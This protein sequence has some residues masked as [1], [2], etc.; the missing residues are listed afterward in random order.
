M[1]SE[2][3]WFTLSHYL[4]DECLQF[5][6]LVCLC[7]LYYITAWR[8]VGFRGSHS[9]SQAT[10]FKDMKIV[11]LPALQDNYMYLV[12]DEATKQAAIVDPV[13]PDTVLEAVK[14]QGVQ[15][16]SILTTH[17]HWDHAGGNEELAK[18][19]PGLEVYGGDERIGALT[20]RV[21]HGDEFQVGQLTVQCLFTP[22]HTSG[23]VCYFVQS[24][25]ETPAVF[26]GDTLF[27]AGCGRFFEG[28]PEQMYKALIEILGS[29]P[30][31]TRVFCGHEYTL[32][33]LKFA[34]HVEPDNEAVKNKMTWAKMKRAKGEPTVPSTIRDE[35][36]FNPFMR[37]T[38]ASVQ[39][40]AG[41]SDDIATMG[42][43]RRE[44]DCFKG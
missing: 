25:G 20:K 41:Q 35:K 43:I 7:S 15:L 22:C 12:I 26:T 28:T 32:A 31:E 3:E 9:S 37:V 33:N 17:H 16:T 44:K 6:N 13:A 10:C 29:L 11:T 39:N 34:E 24:P 1:R 5:T 38:E 40:H 14:A 2:R 36:K 27:I 8:K 23:H 4:G 42:C 19:A 21:G 18:K 30:E